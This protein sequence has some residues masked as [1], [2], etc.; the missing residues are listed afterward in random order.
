MDAAFAEIAQ[1]WGRLDF[2][3]HAIA[4]SDKDKLKGDYVRHDARQLLP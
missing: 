4:F 2:L 1:T 3:V